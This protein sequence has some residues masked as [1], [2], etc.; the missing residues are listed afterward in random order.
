MFWIA[1]AN[2]AAVAVVAISF[3][4]LSRWQMRQHMRERELLVNQ[5]CN[6]AGRPWQDPPSYEAPP[7]E[8]PPDDVWTAPEQMVA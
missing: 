7:L 1:L 5:V 6:L 4:S 8:I 3:A 2:A